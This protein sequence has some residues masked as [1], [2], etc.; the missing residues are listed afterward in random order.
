M[1]KWHF[2]C[3]EKWCRIRMASKGPIVHPTSRWMFGWMFSTELYWATKLPKNFIS[4]T[5]SPALFYPLFTEGFALWL[6][7]T[8]S[9]ES[10]T[11]SVLW[12]V[13]RWL[14]FFSSAS[15]LP[16]TPLWPGIQMLKL[17]MKTIVDITKELPWLQHFI[18]INFWTNL[19]KL[20]WNI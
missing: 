10:G 17:G 13:R 8:W 9:V 12:S 5:T 1:I 20:R 6:M 3:F 4:T 7:N 14:R 16:S 2:A 15:S 11:G 19:C 18:E